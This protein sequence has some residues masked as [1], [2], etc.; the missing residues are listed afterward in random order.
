MCL[1]AEDAPR[2][3]LLEVDSEDT[4]MPSAL[5][6]S[7]HTS[8]MEVSCLNMRQL[9]QVWTWHIDRHG[10]I[11]RCPD[12]VGFLSSVGFQ[13]PFVLGVLL[14]ASGCL[15]VI[16]EAEQI[17]SCVCVMRPVLKFRCDS[18]RTWWQFAV[19]FSMHFLSSKD[20][21]LF[22]S[23]TKAGS[24]RLTVGHSGHPGVSARGVGSPS[25]AKAKAKAGTQ[26]KCFGGEPL[27][28]VAPLPFG[29][30]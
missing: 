19:F 5:A 11:F 8:I 10:R 7:R 27:Q 20:H 15:S 12:L 6:V 23:E 9:V 30:S 22:R 26:R 24:G 1:Q 13:F 18:W 14:R 2:I 21:V 4:S 17:R 28:Q 29:M 3:K 16:Q 25:R